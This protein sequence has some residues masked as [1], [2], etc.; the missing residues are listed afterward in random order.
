FGK[1]T[2]LEHPFI[3]DHETA[4]RVTDYLAKREKFSQDSCDFEVTQ[5]AR[6]LREGDLVQLYY[7]PN[8]YVD[9]LVEVREIEKKTEGNHVVVAGWDASIFVYQ[10]GTLPTDFPPN[11]TGT[12]YI[13]RPG[14]LEL[15]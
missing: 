15:G 4:D 9:A 6:Q 3:R 12:I 1:E 14:G 11:V 8:G 2:V 13:P 7:V 10:P 5:E